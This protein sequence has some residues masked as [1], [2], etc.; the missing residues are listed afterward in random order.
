[1]TERENAERLMNCLLN[2][3]EF[4]ARFSDDR[5][6]VIEDFSVSN[7]ARDAFLQLDLSLLSTGNPTFNWYGTLGGT[8]NV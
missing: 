4:R 2:D 5:V 3:D 8:A 1:M 7:E 6:K